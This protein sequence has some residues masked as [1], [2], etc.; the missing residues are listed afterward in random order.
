MNLQLSIEQV[1]GKPDFRIIAVIEFHNNDIA[2][3]KETTKYMLDAF[4]E[5]FEIETLSADVTDKDQFTTIKINTQ[6]VEKA[7]AL[8]NNIR[9]LLT[10]VFKDEILELPT[11]RGSYSIS[12]KKIIAEMSKPQTAEML[13]INLN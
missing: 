8:R 1:L 10:D 9:E 7:M 5:M 3:R 12:H 2:I 11:D 4:R 13:K 6:D